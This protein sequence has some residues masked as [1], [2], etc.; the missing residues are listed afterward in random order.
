MTKVKI[1]VNGRDHLVEEG[2]QLMKT[3]NDLGLKIPHLCYLER[4]NPLDKCRLCVVEVEGYRNLQVSCGLKVSKGMKIKTNSERVLNSRK[5]TLQLLLSNHRLECTS[6]SSNLHCKLQTYANDFGIRE[7][8]FPEHIRDVVIDTSSLSIVR[9]N[10]KCILCGRCYN[11]CQHE[12]TVGAIGLANRGFNTLVKSPYDINVADSNCVNCGQCVNSCP[13]GALSIKDNTKEVF[14]VLQSNKT[15]VIQTAPSVRVA[16]GEEFGLPDGT[17]VTGK[18]VSALRMLGFDAVYDTD[19]GADLTI[20]EEASEFIERFN[21]GK[22]LPLITSCCPAWVEFLEKFYPNELKYLS[23][24]KSPQAMLSSVLKQILVREKGIKKEDLIVVDVMPCTA[25]KFEARRPELNNETDFVITTVELARMIRKAGIDFNKLK[26]SD[27][28]HPFGESSGAGAI[29]GRSGGVMEAA[30][31]TAVDLMEGKSLKKIDYDF[32]RG[33]KLR[34]EAKL[35]ISGKEVNVCVVHTLGEARKI[36]DEIVEG[37]CKYDFI[38]VMACY[39]GCIG[40]GGQPRYDSLETLHKRAL[41][42]KKEDEGKQIRK[43]HN[44]SEIIALY[45]NHL[46]EFGSKEAHKLLHTKFVKRDSI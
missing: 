12:Q 15:V 9:D 39:G 14:D 16:L 24:C 29:F 33:T 21:S 46:G 19:F 30:L 45:K 1:N 41:A 23:T 28:D 38:E 32:A 6:C 8:R 4:L 26:S 31:R 5:T 35:N 20:V 37:K 10:A 2:K 13:V 43:S 22:K 27:F 17:L 44:N 40:G 36:C 18:M 34:K 3:L 11:I 7:L 42:I 25:K